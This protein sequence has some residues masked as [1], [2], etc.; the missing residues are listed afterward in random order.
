MA[1]G[2]GSPGDLTPEQAA[3]TMASRRYI[4]LLIIVSI[5]GVVV[6]L[7]TWGYLELIHQITQELY[8]HLPNA[9]G[10]QHGPPVGWP[11][12]ILAFAGIWPPFPGG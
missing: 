5:V 3:A 2:P 12:P 6:S 11:L 9:L 8:T 7:A 10:Y 4:V 1:D